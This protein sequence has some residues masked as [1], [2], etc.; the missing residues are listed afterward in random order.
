MQAM[1]YWL[2]ALTRNIVRDPIPEVVLHLKTFFSLLVI[3]SLNI[4]QCL[5]RKQGI[6][7]CHI[8]CTVGDLRVI[9]CRPL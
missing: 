2:S 8:T 3:N 7:V 5:N 6:P 9:Y 4:L 1:F